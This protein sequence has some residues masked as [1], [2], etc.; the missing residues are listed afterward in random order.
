[1]VQAEEGWLASQNPISGR[2]TQKRTCSILAARRASA[3]RSC[4]WRHRPNRRGAL[5]KEKLERHAAIPAEALGVGVDI[6]ALGHPGRA[7]RQKLWRAGHLDK[8]QPAGADVVQPIEVAERRYYDAG[9]GCSFQDGGVVLRADML[10]SMVR[11]FAAI[12]IT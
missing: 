1:V 8:E 6:H 9:I 3:A 2:Y 10:A 5:R 7:G 4:C 11:V 12:G